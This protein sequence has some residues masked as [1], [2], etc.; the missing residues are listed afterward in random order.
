MPVR[1]EEFIQAL[2]RWTSGVT[3]VTSRVGD[4][5]HGM[6][7]SAFASVSLDPPLV[8]ICADKTSDTQALIAEG[9]VFTANILGAEQE[10]LSRRFSASIDEQR[11]FEGVDWRAGSTGAPVLPGCLASLD[12]RVVGA[13]EAGDHVIYVGR[14][15]AV[16]FR[17]AEPLVYHGGTYRSLEE[18]SDREPRRGRRER[19]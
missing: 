15:E 8:L 13:H 12:C 6:T 5:I 19:S 17:D 3:V 14:V 1:P 7:V 11:R 16:A 10:A 4:R 9:R 18:C 2:R